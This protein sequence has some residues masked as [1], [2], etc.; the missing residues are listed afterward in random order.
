MEDNIIHVRRSI[1][2]KLKGGDR[3]TPPKNKSSYR[4]LQGPKK[5]L[6]VLAEQKARQ[7]MQKGFTEDYRICGGE[8]CLRD[9]TIDKHNRQYSA[10]A[11]LPRI[12]IHEFRHSHTS[13][14]I[15]A[16]IN[17][18]E[19][20]RRLGHAK[21]EQTWNTYAHLYPKEEER[22]VAILDSI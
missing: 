11:E 5:L 2:Q 3:E 12:T 14:L 8:K 4:D 19:I 13:V 15:N 1:A 10:D 7:E 22:A 18:Q 21:V 6:Q 16:G 17:I 9:T 20:A